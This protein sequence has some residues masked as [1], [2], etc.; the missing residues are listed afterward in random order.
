MQLTIFDLL[1]DTRFPLQ[2]DENVTLQELKSRIQGN[3][4]LFCGTNAKAFLNSRHSRSLPEAS[5]LW[6]SVTAWQPA[7]A[8]S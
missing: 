4:N 2:V 6:F 1:N 3:G 5:I 7:G 8:R